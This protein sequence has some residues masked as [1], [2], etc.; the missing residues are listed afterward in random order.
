MYRY[1]G[2]QRVVQRERYI[3]MLVADDQGLSISHRKGSMYVSNCVQ[4]FV[5]NYSVEGPLIS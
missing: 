2:M 1:M 4:V 3:R 5:C